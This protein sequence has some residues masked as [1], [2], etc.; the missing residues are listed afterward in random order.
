[1]RLVLIG[2]G[3]VGRKT[4]EF[5]KNHLGS[6]LKIKGVLNSRGM[7][8][9]FRI[10]QDTLQW[11][12]TGEK[13]LGEFRPVCT[14]ALKAFP[15]GTVF[16]DTS[17]AE[18]SSEFYEAILASGHFLVLANKATLIQM[19]KGILKHPNL[20]AEATVGAG[21][22][23]LK[24]IRGL[25]LSE[26]VIQ[27]IRGSFS[28]TLSYLFWAMG[29][30]ASFSEGL[31]MAMEKGYTEPD[32][33]VDLGGVDAFRKVRILAEACGFEPVEFEEL[34]LLNPQ[35]QA[36]PL[37]EFLESGLDRLG[38]FFSRK[39]QEALLENR[40]LRVIGETRPG[41][42]GLRL[43]AVPRDS[44][45]GSLKGAG[46]LFSIQS[47][48]Y[49]EELVVQGPGAGVLRTAAAVFEDV[50][51]LVRLPQ[52]SPEI[53]LQARNQIEAFA[54]AS[55]GNVAAGFDVLGLAIASLGDR[56]RLEIKESPG[57]EVVSIHGDDG[58]LPREAERNTAAIAASHVWKALGRREGLRLHLFKGLP[59]NSGL[60]SSGAS[61]AAAAHAASSLGGGASEE[62]LLQA[63]LLAEGEASGLHLDNAAASLL[64]GLIACLGVEPIRVL[65]LDCHSSLKLGLFIPK[66]EV[67]TKQA[68][69]VLPSTLDLKTAIRS[70]QNFS[71][72]LEAFRS[73]D[74]TWFFEYGQDVLAGV[75]RL[76]L[77]HKAETLFPLA[78]EMGLGL[79]IS[80]AGPAMFTLHYDGAFLQE[81]LE[82]LAAHWRKQGVEVRVS[83]QDI[84]FKGARL[85]S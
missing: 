64:G 39:Q 52:S 33:R 58:R 56:V 18:F 25:Q 49:D 4:V 53:S 50:M 57:I 68:R 54:P 84:D 29:E 66:L 12:Q 23:V 17:V 46:N 13:F 2:P 80:G 71:G 3:Q 24:T 82:T 6:G 70:L 74:S 14:R 15:P 72:C 81:N 67:P 63:C 34:K 21:L 60:G 7:R 19:P 85:V 76:P 27:S 32:P 20:R 30:G 73:G 65:R 55:I 59:L 36:L 35:E 42:A 8:L 47:L 16:V 45:L 22:P 48:M 77:I 61:A 78:K 44:P 62:V 41:Y 28:G 43:E 9:D 37:N 75:H 1:M 51:D 26:D 38:E 40:V 11:V 69:A 5:L 10:H 83:V 31:R 79:S